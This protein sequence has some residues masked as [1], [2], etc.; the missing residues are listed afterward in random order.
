MANLNVL[1]KLLDVTI[2][3]AIT[4]DGGP[5]V[6][7]WFTSKVTG[8]DDNVVVSMSWVNEHVYVYECLLTEG[9]I[10]AGH[11]DEAGA[12]HCN[13]DNGDNT[14]IMFFNITQKT[15]LDIVSIT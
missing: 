7:E 5:L 4:I 3:D 12:F 6:T 11:F 2:T 8:K 15:M 9:G 13:D 14:T 1:L 10:N